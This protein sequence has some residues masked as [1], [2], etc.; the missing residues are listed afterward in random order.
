MSS[1]RRS[2]PA[3]LFTCRND[4]DDEHVDGHEFYQPANER[5]EQIAA[6]MMVELTFIGSDKSVQSR[7][8]ESH[9][10]FPTIISYKPRELPFQARP[11]RM[12]L[13]SASKLNGGASFPAPSIP[14]RR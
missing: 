4:D 11:Q 2:Y 10:F 6:D 3:R 8:I 9:D 12:R 13:R 14:G 1:Q 5:G 7:Q